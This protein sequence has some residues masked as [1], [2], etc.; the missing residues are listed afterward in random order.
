[1]KHQKN[2]EELFLAVFTGEAHESDKQQ[3]RD[4]A[5]LSPENELQLKHF[6]R[7]WKERTQDPLFLHHRELADAIWQK[8]NGEERKIPRYST[9]SNSRK[10]WY[11]PGMAAAVVFI[12]ALAVSLYWL[13]SDDTATETAVA[14]Q[15][16]ITKSNPIGQ[17]T[18]INL[19]DGS[20]AWLNSLS[21]LTYPAYF[22][23][24]SRIMELV[25]EAYFEVKPDS[26]R[27]FTVKAGNLQTT[28]LGTSFNIS[29]YPEKS[30]IS[31]S[32]ITGKV[33]VKNDFSNESIMLLPSHGA[34]YNK[35]KNS[36]VQ[37]NISEAKVLAWKD[38][39]L[40]FDGESFSEF[41]RRLE[42]WYGVEIK[43]IG[44]PPQNWRIR[45]KFDNEYLSNI[46]N[47]ISFNKDFSYEINRKDVVFMFD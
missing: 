14:T 45:G 43:V 32:L 38:G 28:A 13:K 19:P 2:I 21:S 20:V 31:V 39:V 1:M 46:L 6:E 33:S 47:S 11:A 29:A 7:V 17:K 16:V 41:V 5:E 34:V 40:L 27:P 26:L 8:A 35:D 25:G 44:T 3:L 24:S 9:I 42:V 12:A 37:V 23:D 10:R 15:Q 22:S 4:W 30:N 18:R 36:L